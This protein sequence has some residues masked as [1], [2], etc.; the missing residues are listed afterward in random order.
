MFQDFSS[1]QSVDAIPIRLQLFR[2]K[3]K[4]NNIKAWL[5]SRTDEY[6]GEYLAPY[7][8]RLFYISGFS[9][10]AGQAVIGVHHAAIFIDGRYTSQVK[11]ECDQNLFN[12]QSLSESNLVDWI[13]QHFSAGDS[14]GFNAELWTQHQ[15]ENLTKRLD[16]L[17]ISLLPMHDLID[18]IW[19]D[20]PQRPLHKAFLHPIQYTG[21]HEKSKIER[22][23][24]KL[25]EQD[26]DYLYVPQCDNICWLLNI[27][28][29]DIAHNPI[30]HARAIIPQTGKVMLFISKEKWSPAV[31]SKLKE[32]VEI[33]EPEEID[34]YLRNIAQKG[35][36]F[37]L[38]P[39]II[40]NH[41]YKIIK[42]TP[43]EIKRLSNPIVLMQAIKNETEIQNHRKAQIYDFRA[44]NEFISWFHF[45]KR[46]QTL[47][48]ISA[49]KKM[50]ECRKNTG[51][52]KEISF[53]TISGFAANGAIVHYRVN[54][55]TNKTIEG[56]GLFLLDSGGQYL[57]GTTDITRT[58]LVGKPTLEMIH[59]YTLVLKGHI[60]LA[61]AIFPKGTTGSQ[62]DSLARQYLWENGLD[63][64][65]GTG[66]GIGSYLNVH[67]GPQS[68]SKFS[69]IPLEPGM[70]L[71]N[72]PGYYE[73]GNFGIRLENLIL[74]KEIE[75]H[76][77]ER[78]MLC[79]ETLSFVP[80]ENELID[81]KLLTIK[82]KKW[83]RNYMNNCDVSLG[84]NQN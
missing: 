25:K 56:N 41:I 4:Q 46:S 61:S 81:Q 28:G 37:S 70:I 43:S 16:P 84:N 77:G 27:R 47:T 17:N 22:L 30:V 64:N 10:S 18:D 65:H 62:L 49:A 72:E 58:F 50:E 57:E 34:Q 1:S 21:E 23:Q 38:D 35:K 24:K 31:A 48:E 83:L 39:K 79:F 68:I 82:E 66:H 51:A 44:M 15:I 76:K 26:V 63:Y 3:L 73:E 6:R 67:E 69:M 71:S 20:K 32:V 36:I 8:E 29:C 40:S 53:D 45:H 42:A 52:L 7:A 60:A 55:K 5:L 12:F 75:F 78:K 11:Q 33:Y 59:K 19:E 74:V 80:F 13:K 9:G 54:E 14:L 2:E